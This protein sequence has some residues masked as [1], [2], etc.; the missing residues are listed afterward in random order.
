MNR[1]RKRPASRAGRARWTKADGARLANWRGANGWT[2]DDL[3]SK[4][5]L[6]RLS[7]S[8]WEKGRRAPG[9]GVLM[10]LA[11]LAEGDDS[12]WF[13]ERSGVEGGTL[14]HVDQQAKGRTDLFVTEGLR[15]RKGF[16]RYFVT[17]ERAAGYPLQKG[18]VLFLDESLRGSYRLRPFWDQPILIEVSSSASSARL[19]GLKFLVGRPFLRRSSVAAPATIVWDILLQPLSMIERLVPFPIGMYVDESPLVGLRATPATARSREAFEDA[20]RAMEDRSRERAEEKAV[21]DADFHIRGVVIGWIG[22]DRRRA[23]SKP[24]PEEGKGAPPAEG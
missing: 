21:L 15:S 19:G 22:I 2:Q 9:P 6:S 20:Y 7:V 12:V 1:K 16:T 5:G 24:R 4:V 13:W 17:E 23:I 8:G 18:D 11:H 10:R 3:A 14:Q